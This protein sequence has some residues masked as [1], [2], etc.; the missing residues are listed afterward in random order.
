MSGAGAVYFTT[1]GMD[2]WEWPT[3]LCAAAILYTNPVQLDVTTRVRARASFTG[4][5]SACNEA[6]FVVDSPPFRLSELMYHPANPPPGG[7]YD[8]D[9]FE[10]IEIV[11]VD[12][13]A[14]PLAG[15]SVTGNVYFAFSGESAPLPA[16]ACVL[17]VR[18]AEAF[19][20]R[21]PTNGMRIAGEYAGKLA[22]DTSVLELRDATYG[23]IV[24]VRYY[25]WWRPPTDGDGFALE[26]T[27][28][29]GACAAWSDRGTWLAGTK[30]GGTPGYTGIPEPGILA[31]CLVCWS[32]LFYS[33]TRR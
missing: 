19:A 8:A 22:N 27:N 29:L 2:P 26:V 16:S 9:A 1:N 31:A 30:A 21:Y 3:G 20:S 13:G 23:P 12:D 14:W 17:V 6:V 25:D 33:R 18:N 24:S 10:F 11:N 15:L 7:D 4:I 5:W 28:L 32:G